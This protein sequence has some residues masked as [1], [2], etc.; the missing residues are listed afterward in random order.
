MRSRVCCPTTRITGYRM[1]AR[2]PLQI[3]TKVNIKEFGPITRYAVG[4]TSRAIRDRARVD[5]AQ[6]GN[7]GRNWQMGLKT[8][9][10]R[11]RDRSGYVISVTQWPNIAPVFQRGATS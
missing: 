1:A 7:F 8:R 6:G 4:A 10:D 5:I 11:I 2:D 9:V 3:D